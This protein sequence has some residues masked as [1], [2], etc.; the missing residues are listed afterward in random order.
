MRRLLRVFTYS[1]QFV[2]NACRVFGR[3]LVI[4]ADRTLFDLL[5]KSVSL[6]ND[7]IAL[8]TPSR[9]SR[10][11]LQLE[12][13]V[14]ASRPCNPVRDEDHSLPNPATTERTLKAHRQTCQPP[15]TARQSET[16]EP[17]KMQTRRD[18]AR[19][20]WVN[21]RCSVHKQRQK[22]SMMYREMVPATY[23]AHGS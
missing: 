7:Q 19:C 16:S 20:E 15:S 9:G 2:Y 11:S 10:L 17:T 8:S 3:F 23:G 5:Q 6:W 18:A 1:T 12:M 14:L 13:F 4:L 21:W 22:K